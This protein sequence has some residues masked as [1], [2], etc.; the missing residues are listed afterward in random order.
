MSR[1][2]KRIFDLIISVTGLILLSPVLVLIAVVIKIH[3][4]GSIFYKAP[5][6]GLNG[7]PFY[8][9]KFRTMIPDAD[10]CGP[11][12]SS[13][14]DVRVTPTGRY[15]RKYKLDE[16]P[17]LFNVLSGKMSIIGP[18]PE[19]KKFTDMYSNEEKKILS[20]KPG[21]TDWATIWNSNESELLEGSD[22]PDDYYL[23][24]I[25]PEKLRLQLL[26]TKRHNFF[27]DLQIFFLTIRKIV[28]N[29]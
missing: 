5:R 28:F 10:K 11:S 27:I 20:V 7:A 15:L 23:K 8:M 18:R 22:D 19:E 29:H 24:Y 1:I 3:H 2:S 14:S 9:Y 12:S 17:Q 4:A 13:K 6:T 26:Y 25:R 21:I 16:I